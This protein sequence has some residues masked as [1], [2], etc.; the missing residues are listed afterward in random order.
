MYVRICI[1]ICI[2]VYTVHTKVNV[3]YV[4][5]IKQIAA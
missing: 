5:M 4:L 1:C 2:H 3:L